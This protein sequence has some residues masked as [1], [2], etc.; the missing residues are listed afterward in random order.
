M[1]LKELLTV[2]KEVQTIESRCELCICI[3]TCI[4]AVPL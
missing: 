2:F 4:K 1:E 3:P